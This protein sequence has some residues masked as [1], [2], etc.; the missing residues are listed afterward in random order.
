MG[1]RNIN[2]KTKKESEMA[3][4]ELYGDCGITAV[5]EDAARVA[6]ENVID[7]EV[8]HQLPEEYARYVGERVLAVA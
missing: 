6:H 7:C 3:L 5:D 8:A 1:L 2:V 4:F